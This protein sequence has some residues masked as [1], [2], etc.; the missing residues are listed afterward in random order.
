MKNK[1]IQKRSKLIESL[2]QIVDENGNYIFSKD[3]LIE[4]FKITK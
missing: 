2:S 4:R 1:V 3:W